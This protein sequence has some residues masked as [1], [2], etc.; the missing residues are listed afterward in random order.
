[1]QVKLKVTVWRGQ[2]YVRRLVR[3]WAAAMR[4]IRRSEGGEWKVE[5]VA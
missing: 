1:M 5:V 4:L 3:G 2:A